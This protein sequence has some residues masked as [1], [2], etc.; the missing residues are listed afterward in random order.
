MFKGQFKRAISKKHLVETFK[1]HN[2]I[3][4]M[5]YGLESIYFPGWSRGVIR[6]PYCRV[7]K[8]KKSKKRKIRIFE[9]TGFPGPDPDQ[10]VPVH[11]GVT[12]RSQEVRR[13]QKR[14]KKFFRK[15]RISRIRIRIS[16]SP[17]M[18]LRSGPKGLPVA[19]ISDL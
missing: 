14:R 15:N 18:P 5:A 13:S 9:K 16:G 4:D 2:Y 8:L 1:N 7:F 11:P 10:V 3:L 12:L 17:P 6:H 19:K